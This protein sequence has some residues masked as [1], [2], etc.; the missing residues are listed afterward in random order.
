MYAHIYAGRK[1][2]LIEERTQN[3]IRAQVVDDLLHN[4]PIPIDIPLIYLYLIFLNLYFTK[5]IFELGFLSISNLIFAG[6][7]DSKNQVWNI[8]R[9]QMKEKMYIQKFY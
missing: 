3:E 6:Y 2:K 4:S 1:K 8:D 7:T 9:S 5:L